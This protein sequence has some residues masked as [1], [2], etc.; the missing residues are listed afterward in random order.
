MSDHPAL[1]RAA[2]KIVT[3]QIEAMCSAERILAEH[4]IRDQPTRF[5]SNS[6]APAPSTM[7]S[8][9]KPLSRSRDY[10]YSTV[11]TEPHY[12]GAS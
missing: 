12:Q 2:G 6:S 8:L 7:R 10:R 5:K 1:K 4:P 9:Q 3:Y 11:H